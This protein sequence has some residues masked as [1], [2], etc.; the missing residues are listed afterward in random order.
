MVESVDA[1]SNV[2]SENGYVDADNTIVT[3]VNQASR[4]DL[5][6]MMSSLGIA[7]RDLGM[8]DKALEMQEC[9]LAMYRRILPADH[10]DIASSMHN[11]AATYGD[12]G[13]HDKALE[14]QECTLTMRCRLL[15]VATLAMLDSLPVSVSS[16]LHPCTLNKL[17]FIYNGGYGCDVCGKP[18]DLDVYHCDECG[19]D[20]HPLCICSEDGSLLAAKEE[21]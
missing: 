3:L 2:S 1:V 16:P 7:Y 20:A 19:W 21:K 17:P 12:L 13:M 10:P 14:M 6:R 9:T 11:L 15:P 18:G 4:E 8:H 5:L